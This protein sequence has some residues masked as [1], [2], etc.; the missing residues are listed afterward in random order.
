SRDRAPD[1]AQLSGR[2]IPGR[3]G[4]PDR[5]RQGAGGAL[6]RAARDARRDGDPSRGGGSL[7]EVRDGVV[8]TGSQELVPFG[9]IP[10]ATGTRF[11]VYAPDAQGVEVLVENDGPK[12]RAF[13]M[14]PGPDGV[15]E[16]FVEGVSVGA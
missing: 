6:L 1:G 13:P 2:A 15:H 7:M 4:W 12:S 16:C 8:G 3:L 9:A 14:T 5:S 11:R 10:E